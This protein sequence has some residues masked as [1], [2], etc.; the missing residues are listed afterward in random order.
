MFA[1]NN[2]EIYIPPLTLHPVAEG[3]PG[4]AQ[5]FANA[6]VHDAH[7]AKATFRIGVGGGV[8]HLS[9]VQ[10][11]SR[12]HVEPTLQRQQDQQTAGLIRYQ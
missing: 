11:T 5:V 9:P 7:V 8:C 4:L 3:V 2:T 1:K 12:A 6:V 10:P